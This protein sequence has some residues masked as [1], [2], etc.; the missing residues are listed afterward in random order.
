MH[1]E[2]VSQLPINESIGGRELFRHVEPVKR[3]EGP[4]GVCHPARGGV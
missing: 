2:G 3:G 4:N 1:V